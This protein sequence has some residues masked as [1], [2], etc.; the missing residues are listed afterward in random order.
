MRILSSLVIGLLADFIGG[1]LTAPKSGRRTRKELLHE[2]DDIQDRLNEGYD[3]LLGDTRREVDSI[4]K[5][6]RKALD[7][8]QK[9]V[10]VNR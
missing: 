9:T 5:K 2:M 1:I 10:Q 3:S 4:S 8:F 7:Q 6:G